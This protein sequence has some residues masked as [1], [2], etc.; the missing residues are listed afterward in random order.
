MFLDEMWTSFASQTHLCDPIFTHLTP[1]VLSAV[2]NFSGR[3]M[4]WHFLSFS[5]FLIN[6]SSF[7]GHPCCPAGGTLSS[8][9]LWETGT[10]LLWETGFAFM[11]RVPGIWI[12][13]SSV[14][15]K[16]TWNQ[17]SKPCTVLQYP[18]KRAF[19][20]SLRNNVWK[21]VEHPSSSL[22]RF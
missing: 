20:I 19:Y 18:S 4:C 12:N 6:S 2:L 21:Q 5:Y 10:H 13:E 17:S 14:N 9:M 15:P 16:S 8:A 3:S 1:I 11:S 22:H 7:V